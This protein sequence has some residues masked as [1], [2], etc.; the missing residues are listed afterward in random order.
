MPDLGAFEGR[1]VYIVSVKNA[2]WPKGLDRVTDTI[3]LERLGA[4][5]RISKLESYGIKGLEI[6]PA[7]LAKSKE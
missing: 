3:H 7:V 4:D 2:T 1:E 6:I 5:M